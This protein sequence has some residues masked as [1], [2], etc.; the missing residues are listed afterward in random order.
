MWDIVSYDFHKNITEEKVKSNVLNNVE[1]GS[2]IVF[3]DNKK[4]KKIL[5]LCLEEILQNL[6]KKG[7]RFKTI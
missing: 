1:N 6:I 5:K 3:H 2:I 4:S 7:Y